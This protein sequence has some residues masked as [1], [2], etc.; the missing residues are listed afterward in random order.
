MPGVETLQTLS[1]ALVH[2][3]HCSL[4]KMKPQGKM[5]LPSQ[6]R[7]YAAQVSTN[8]NLMS[9]YLE[10]QNSGSA[11]VIASELAAAQTKLAEA[12]FELLNLSRDTGSFLVHLT[13]DVRGILKLLDPDY[14]S[15]LTKWA[16]SSDLRL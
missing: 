9:Q 16:V 13:V 4:I 6:I 10:N 7:Q 15:M 1:F 11:N 14:R 8:A 3:S 2:P 5:S 12:A